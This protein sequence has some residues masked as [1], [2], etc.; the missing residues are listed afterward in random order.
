MSSTDATSKVAGA[1]E[2]PDPGTKPGKRKQWTP[3]LSERVLIGLFLGILTGIV[4]G[5]L[6]GLIG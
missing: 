1:P 2:G 5:A 3:G 6:A 4:F